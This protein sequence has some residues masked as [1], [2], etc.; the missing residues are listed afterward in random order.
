MSI[1]LPPSGTGTLIGTVTISGKDYPQSIITDGV[2]P[3]SASVN[4]TASGVAV[5][6]NELAVSASLVDS[7]KAT[8]G[9]A[10]S[11]LL[12]TAAA[13]TDIAVLAG[14]ASKTVKVISL[15]I[16]GS[17]ATTAVYVDYQVFKRS[18][19]FSGGTGTGATAVP[20]DSASAAA[21]AVFTTFV[22]TG[23]TVGTAVGQI[24]AQ[25]CYLPI[26]GSNVLGT[27]VLP[28]ALL[29]GG[30]SPCQSVT[31]RGVAQAIG[32]NCNTVTFGTAPN[33]SIDIIWT[34]E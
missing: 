27:Q 20:F 28:A 19:A 29:I 17:I 11:G 9:A 15:R 32:L 16:S 3:A 26:T 22:S 14:S 2:T 6:V 4:T 18:T 5:R 8:Y 34:E 10:V 1:Q 33:F 25:R 12:P 23:P 31:L 7:G 30:S 21:T 13:T 24:V